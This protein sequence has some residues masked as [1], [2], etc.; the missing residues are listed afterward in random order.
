VRLP[1]EPGLLE[2]Y[3]DEA[4]IRDAYW[5]PRR[6]DVVI[7]AGAAVGSYAIPALIA[8]ARVIAVDPDAGAT[9]KLERVAALNGL[10]DYEIRHCA[11][12]DSG[13]YPDDMRA[14]LEAGGYSYLIPP[15]GTEFITLDDVGASLDRL[16]WVKADVEGAELGLLRGGMSTLTRFHPRLLIEDHTEVYPFVAEMRSRHLCIEL[17]EGLGYSVEVI[18]WGP[19]PRSYL[20]AA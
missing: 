16:D 3:A 10:Q 18:P 2:A 4:P 1:D 14:A 15:R 20:V 9:A 8:G 12:F 13:G 7:D 6:G 5:K 19:P 17:L 11:L